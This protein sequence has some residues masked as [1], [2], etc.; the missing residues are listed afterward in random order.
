MSRSRTGRGKKSAK[1]SQKRSAGTSRR[2]ASA[3]P[4]GK[5]GTSPQTETPRPTGA[6]SYPASKHP[7]EMTTDEA[8]THLFHPEV[9]QHAK[10]HLDDA[11]RRA[12]N[13]DD[14]IE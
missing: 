11:A 8:V 3:K 14:E 12:E 13:R 1:S 6:G 2:R 10:R 4:Q 9:V 7:H 5:R